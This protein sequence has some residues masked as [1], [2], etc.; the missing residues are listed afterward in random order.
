MCSVPPETGFP[1]LAVDD[2]DD[3]PPHAARLTAAIPAIAATA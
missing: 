3:D 1:E 2:D